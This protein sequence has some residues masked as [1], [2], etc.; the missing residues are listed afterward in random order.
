MSSLADT[1]K[2]LPTFDSYNGIRINVLH[3]HSAIAHSRL[4][5]LYCPVTSSHSP[6]NHRLLQIQLGL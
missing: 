6:W 2:L 1:K 4:A 3:G 5:A